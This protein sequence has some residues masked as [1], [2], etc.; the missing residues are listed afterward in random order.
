VAAKAGHRG[1]TRAPTFDDIF[2]AM[3]T[4]S[5]G[6]TAARVPLPDSPQLDDP[7]TRL[8]IALNLLLEDLA[9][10][11]RELG[12]SEA[13]YRQLFESNPIPMWVYNTESLAF[14]AVNDAAVHKYGY[15]REEFLRMTIRDIRPPEDV[16]KLLTHI[17]AG[18]QTN[19]P[20][21]WRH[22]RK[23][24]SLI[25]VE[26]SLREL[27]WSG[28]PAYLVLANDVTARERAQDALR[29]S[30]A[31]FT[32]LSESGL[33]GITVTDMTGRVLEANDSFLAMIQR[34][35]EDLQ[36]GFSSRDITPPEYRGMTEAAR[37]QLRTQGVARTLEKEYL[38]PDGTRVR[39]VIGSSLLDSE[40]IISFILDISERQ[41]LEQLRQQAFELETENRRIQE[42]SRLKSQ[43]LGNMSHE[44]RTPLNAILGFTDVLLMSMAGPLTAGQ[45]EHLEVIKNGAR[46]LLSLINDLLDLSRIEAGKVTIV[47]EEVHVQRL[48]EEVHASL[49]PLADAKALAFDLVA[50][51]EPVHVMTDARALKQIVVNLA[52]NAIKFTSRGSVTLRL[53]GRRANG[54][55]A[56][57][58]AIADTGI[59][60]RHCDRER[61]FN[62]FAQMDRGAREGSGLGLHLSRNLAELLGGTLDFDS[63]Y[64]EGSRFWLTLPLRP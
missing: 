6:N 57:E 46:H 19:Q 5:V 2:A 12:A 31:R 43:F 58:I 42:A 7:T 40:R 3:S 41:R 60:I 37:A 9:F 10:R 48:L 8:A 49:K 61:M 30:E 51:R 23:D 59:G 11:E 20:S 64:G 53:E 24:G 38:R 36:R 44:L 16:P 18:E 63:V 21:L 28:R 32:R 13:R 47:R 29:R 27:S 14:C 15:S 4:A 17:R 39:A 52:G 26:I 22:R 35:R 62:A 1:V 45:R 34:S 50:P 54:A 25:D 55:D 56:I 33:L